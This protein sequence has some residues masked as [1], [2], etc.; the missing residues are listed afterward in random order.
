MSSARGFK[1]AGLVLIAL[2]FSA[3]AWGQD[4]AALQR[5]RDALQAKIAT[6][7]KLL[8]QASS[9][10]QDALTQLRLINERMRLREQLIRHH[11]SEIRALERSMS[12]ADSEIRALEGHISALKDEYARMIQAAYKLSLSQNPWMYV[13]AAE[14]FM[15]AT[16]RFQL[17]Q[18]Y[19]TLR[20]EHVMQIEA[21]QVQLGENK[22]SLE[23]KRSE[24]QSVLAD[25]RNERDRLVDDQRKRTELVES[26]K[27]EESR[28]RAEVRQAEAE[29]T[30]LNTAIRKIIEAELAAERAS[31]AG[32]FA[33]TPAGKIAS[34]AFESN[35]SAL[36]WPVMRGVMTGKFGRQPHPS[37]PGITIDNNGIDIST[38]LGSSVLAVFGG[39]VSSIFSI[40]GAGQT[41]ILSHG[42]FRTVYSNLE[43]V[44]VQKGASIE[45]GEPLGTVRTQN[46]R[47]VLH[48]EVW[49]VEGSTQTPQDPASWLV[50]N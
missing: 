44:R 10:K 40:P 34:A 30:R 3:L 28:L 25:V 7:E 26:L 45:A 9:N 31:S 37:L 43:T 1:H 47:A 24:R 5:E 4:K 32:E 27:G 36:P 22:R 39:T 35:R 48:F 11:E 12:N 33:L 42:A 49:R 50:R 17:L 14:D 18:S 29:K 16:I 41:I 38:E 8:N 2:V 21:S 20:K 46:N 6:T 23:A 15:Q 19:S 13:F